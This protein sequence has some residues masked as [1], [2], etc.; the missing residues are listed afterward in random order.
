VTYDTGGTVSGGRVACQNLDSV[1]ENVRLSYVW[2]VTRTDANGTYSLTTAR[3]GRVACVAY[4]PSGDAQRQ[5]VDI[6]SDGAATVNFQVCHRP[7]SPVQYHGGPV[8]H[9]SNAYLIFWLP[10][11]YTYEPVGGSNAHFQALM[12]RYFRDIGGSSFY[13]LLTQYWDFEG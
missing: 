1:A 5:E 8:M 11:G 3:P 2:P 9:T 6:S 10:K 7:C 12:Q 4:A 13:G